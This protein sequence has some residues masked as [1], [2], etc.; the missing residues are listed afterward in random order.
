VVGGFLYALHLLDEQPM[1]ISRV[2]VSDVGHDGADDGTNEGIVYGAD[3]INAYDVKT[4]Y[5]GELSA[6]LVFGEGAGTVEGQ[7][8]APTLRGFDTAVN[9]T[10][11][12]LR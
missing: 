4:K 12:I 8:V 7:S 2:Q 11:T 10:L 5:Q 3:L 1:L 6:S 9:A